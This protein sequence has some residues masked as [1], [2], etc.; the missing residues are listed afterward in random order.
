MA[1][2]SLDGLSGI[3]SVALDLLITGNAALTSLDGLSSIA[4]VGRDLSIEDNAALSAC[5]C[6]IG[7]LLASDGVER[8]ISIHTNLPGCNS[9]AEVLATPCETSTG[10]EDPLALPQRVE[11]KNNYPNPFKGQTTIR[12][13]LPETL[14]VSLVVYD[15][16]GRR[17]RMLVDDAQPPGWREIIFEAGDLPSGVYFYRLEAG[18]FQE[19][20]QMLLVK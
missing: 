4:S 11:L 18:S 9:P 8:T 19:M 15:V 13:G 3:S 10:V 14:S 12:Y 5:S 2:T 1:L 16:Q 6:G 20:G 17:V 7:G